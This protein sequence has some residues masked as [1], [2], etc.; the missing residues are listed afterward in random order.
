MPKRTPV[1]YVIQDMYVLSSTEFVS[2]DSDQNSSMT[3]RMT[4]KSAFDVTLPTV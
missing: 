1:L 2:S 4:P 3:N